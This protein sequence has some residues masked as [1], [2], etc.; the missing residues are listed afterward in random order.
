MESFA[1]HVLMCNHEEV[2]HV[3]MEDT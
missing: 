3:V 2:A 1:L